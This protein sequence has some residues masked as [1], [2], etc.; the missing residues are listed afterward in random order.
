MVRPYFSL[1]GCLVRKKGQADVQRFNGTGQ[2]FNQERARDRIRKVTSD[3][4]LKFYIERVHNFSPNVKLR[5]A[6]AEAS[7]CNLR[8][9]AALPPASGSARNV[10]STISSVSAIVANCKMAV[11]TC[12]SESVTNACDGCPCSNAVIS[13]YAEPNSAQENGGRESI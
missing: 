11:C 12:Y 13:K 6:A 8:A 4:G 9:P 5:Q 10:S 7:D 1:S 3:L 2:V